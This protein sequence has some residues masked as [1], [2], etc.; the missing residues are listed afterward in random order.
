M[1]V[2]ELDALS[3]S[4]LEDEIATLG[5]H[6]NAGM[7]RWLELVGERDRRGEWLDCT[8]SEWLAWRCALEPRTAREHVRVARCLPE[9]LLIRAAFARGELSYSKV[10]ALTRIADAGSEEDLLPMARAMTASQLE[11]AVRAYRRVTTAGANDLHDG[12][13]VTS[14]WEEDGSLAIHG[15]LA[16]ED[17]AVFLK[18]MDAARDALWERERGSAEP[19]TWPSSAETIVAMADASLASGGARSGGERY[20]VLVH[21]DLDALVTDDTEGGCAVDDGPS[22]AP[23]TARRLACDC[24]M[25]TMRE[26][27]GIPLSVGRK[28][29]SIP[30]ALRRALDRRDGRCRFPGCEH[31]LWLHG[32]HIEHWIRG[33]ETRLDNLLLLCF[34]HH[35]LVHEG[36]YHVDEQMRFYNPWGQE[37]PAVAQPPPGDAAELLRHEHAST[38][39]PHTCTSG[40]GE[41]MDL[42]LQVEAIASV[43]GYEWGWS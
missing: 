10:R 19:R 16:P 31:R 5:S 15:R 3:I 34:R 20:Q 1:D 18:A 13:Y 24:S 36:G 6:L 4:E 12:A 27:D 22:L 35:R 2:S 25:V 7:C 43:T 29:R 42:E 23:E 40:E 41:R 33:G 39:G 21:V 11:R 14:F 9:L 26:R 32:H 38:I 28:T 37:I 17:G 30:P 8:C